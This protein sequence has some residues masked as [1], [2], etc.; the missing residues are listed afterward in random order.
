MNT[1]ILDASVVV[2]YLLS[3]SEEVAK[4]LPLL[5]RGVKDSKFKL[6]SSFLLSLEVCNSLRF[7]LVDKQ[8]LETVLSKL[9]KL[10]IKYLK[11]TNAQLSEAAS[12]SYDLGTTVYDTSYHI[13]AKAHNAI[14]LTCDEDYYKKAKNLGDIE[15]IG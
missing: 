11:L 14:F 5:L 9:F 1:Y 12:L 3:S 10:P 2:R 6:Y 13:L 7:S 8:K 4:R 15:F